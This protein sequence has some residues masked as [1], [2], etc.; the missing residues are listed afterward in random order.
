MAPVKFKNPTSAMQQLLRTMLKDKPSLV[1]R[2]PYNYQQIILAM[3]PLLSGE[4]TFKQFCNISTPHAECNNQMHVCIG[5]HVLSNHS[6]RNIK[7]HSPE[8]HLLAW[9]KKASAYI[10]CNSLGTK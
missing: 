6:L 9:L 1:L 8:N 5:C 3:T 2:T 4:K 10:E 7:F